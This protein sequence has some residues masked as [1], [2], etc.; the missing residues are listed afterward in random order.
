M[1]LIHRWPLTSGPEDVVGGLATT[2]NGGVTFDSEGGHFNGSNQW[3]SCDKT[4][5]SSVTLSVWV[6]PTDIN[7]RMSMLYGGDA[8]GSTCTT[9]GIAA[10]HSS[11]STLA[12][13][14][15]GLIEMPGEFTLANY[16]STQKT[17]AVMTY[18]SAAQKLAYYR[19]GTKITEGDLAA[20]ATATSFAIG[21]AGLYNGVY[22]KG[23]LAD[24]RIY[25]HALLQSEINA[26]VDGGPNGDPVGEVLSRPPLPAVL[27][28][29][30]ASLT[31]GFRV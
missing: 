17:L 12:V 22:W 18:D 26:L 16:P 28:C 7:Q 3:L 25:D 11:N 15:C 5:P 9:W 20:G 21:R 13:Y 4:R 2:N 10:S 8:E 29:L 23:I 6:T 14:M 31:L 27:S 24:A 30:P 19:N 1:A